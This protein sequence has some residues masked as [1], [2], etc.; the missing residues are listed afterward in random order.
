MSLENLLENFGIGKKEKVYLSVSQPVGMEVFQ[1]DEISGHITKYACKAVPY[2]DSTKELTD[3]EKFREVFVDLLTELGLKT[4]CNVVLNLPTVLLGSREL[5]TMLEDPA[6]GQSIL[7]EIESSYVFSRY[8]PIFDWK[9]FSTGKNA[10]MRNIFYCALQDNILSKI[11]ELLKE[12]GAKVIDIQTSYTTILNGLAR[13]N[14]VE[15][16]LQPEQSWNLMVVN[17]GGYAIFSMVAN[18]IVDFVQEDMP[19]MEERADDIY[20]SI[21]ATAEL[22][23]LGFPANSLVVVSESDQVNAEELVSSLT[24]TGSLNYQHIIH[25]DDNLYRREEFL[26]L[27]P[28][29]DQRYKLKP[30]LKTIGMLQ[31][32]KYP[33]IAKF[34]FLKVTPKVN[35]SNEIVRFAIADRVFEITPSQAQ[36]YSAIAAGVLLVILLPFLIIMPILNKPFAEKISTL[37]TQITEL[38]SEIA[39]INDNGSSA[40]FVPAD[41]IKNVLANNRTKLISYIT[42]GEVIPRKLWITYYKVHS[43][44]KIIIAGVSGSIDDINEFYKNINNTLPNSKLQLKNLAMNNTSEEDAAVAEAKYYDFVITNDDSYPPEAEED[45][46]GGKKSKNKSKKKK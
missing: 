4:S 44:D 17:N 22:T 23:L 9:D 29:V 34:D 7:A 38:E 28:T 39:A 5:P 31:G 33:V 16:Q 3:L 36:V 42:I 20:N 24:S 1:V 43:K 30:S 45:E 6:I 25:I 13:T 41:E 11:T 46:E 32:V 2:D 27:A 35:Y 14:L 10:G 8:T 37:E 21:A 40:K 26:P 18:R 19:L 15:R 12:I